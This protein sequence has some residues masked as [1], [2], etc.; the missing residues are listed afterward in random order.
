M[1]RTSLHNDS[2]LYASLIAILLL[3]SYW[4]TTRC[5]KI[6]SGIEGTGQGM[7]GDRVAQPGRF[8]KPSGEVSQMIGEREVDWGLPL[9]ETSISSVTSLAPPGRGPALM[10][11]RAASGLS[12]GSGLYPGLLRGPPCYWC[13]GTAALSVRWGC[14]WT[15]WS[16][17]FLWGTWSSHSDLNLHFEAL[18][19]FGHDPHLWSSA[20][21]LGSS[22]M[23]WGSQFPQKGLSKLPAVMGCECW[24]FAGGDPKA[25]SKAGGV[26]LAS[27]VWGRAEPL[28][29]GVCIAPSICET[30][31]TAQPE[32]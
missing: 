16:L 20:G 10:C 13:L 23:W 12:C 31:C 11:V 17:P 27:H 26:K 4:F 14:R 28:L 1:E 8:H 19:L 18:G 3:I 7:W 29:P 2:L 9:W 32:P 24:R 5:F 6:I 22:G 15:L 21:V 25:R 30:S